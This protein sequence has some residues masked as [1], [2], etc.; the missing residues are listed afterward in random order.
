MNQKKTSKRTSLFA[1]TY[2][3]PNSVPKD[4]L[5]ILKPIDS[6]PKIKNEEQTKQQENELKKYYENLNNKL[7]LNLTESN[8]DEHNL[9]QQQQ[10]TN[11]L[12]NE[13]NQDQLDKKNSNYASYFGINRLANYFT[14]SKNE[15]NC[16]NTGNNYLIPSSSGNELK[17]SQQ[18]AHSLNNTITSTIAETTANLISK[19]N[20]LN[21]SS[22]YLLPK[23]HWFYKVPSSNKQ[24]KDSND[25]ASTIGEEQDQQQDGNLT[26]SNLDEN[27][28]PF[29][30]HDSDALDRA[31][32][33]LDTNPSVIVSTNGDRYDCYL[34]DRFRRS[35]Y[36]TETDQEIRRCTWYFKKEGHTKF[37]PY[38]EQFAFKLEQIYY[39]VLMNSKWN[40][41]IELNS[42][43]QE[44]I[45]FYSYNSIIHYELN[46]NLI[47]DEWNTVNENPVKPKVVNRELTI[48][49]LENYDVCLKED[50]LYKVDHLVF[51]VKLIF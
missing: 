51:L 25:K 47:K 7:N 41:R 18:Q 1:P 19:T 45:I 22:F 13:I 9:K 34:K 17:E 28:L 3:S 42:T 10:Q 29:A 8:I 43:N 46:D 39:D 44:M 20:Y 36:W 33:L 40:Q 4:N 16:E 5:R 24:S 50:E 49:E 31:Y 26:D 6:L 30:F 2:S 12:N 27:W 21:E 23:S 32:Q 38:T 48:D 35:V 11:E 37:I 15:M 14:S